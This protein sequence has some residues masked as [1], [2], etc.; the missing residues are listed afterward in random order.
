MSDKIFS[1][2]YDRKRASEAYQQVDERQ[3]VLA[4]LAGIV[5][6]P[7]W[8]GSLVYVGD[9]P[10]E[11]RQNVCIAIRGPEAE[12]IQERLVEGF[13]KAGIEVLQIYEGGPEPTYT[14]AKA[15]DGKWVRANE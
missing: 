5:P 11:Q 6:Q 13:E 3:I 1:L 10:D 7:S 12:T 9:P 2:V 8:N 15:S 14:I 4:I